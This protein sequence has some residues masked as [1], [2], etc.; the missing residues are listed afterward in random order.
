MDQTERKKLIS[1]LL[2]DYNISTVDIDAVL[3]GEKQRAGHYT[4]EML[5]Q[6]I[7]ESYPWFTVLKLFTP[8]EISC[9]LTSNTINKL[10][11]PSLKKKYEFVQKRLQQIVP[12]PG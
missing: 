6:K 8:V 7:L 1:Q 12:L 11:S 3:K 2:W 5:F 9:L 10:R 4:R